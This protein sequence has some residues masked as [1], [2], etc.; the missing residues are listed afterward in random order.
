MMWTSSYWKRQGS[1]AC[2]LDSDSVYQGLT[3]RESEVRCRSRLFTAPRISVPLG[4]AR[5][6]DARCGWKQLSVES[7]FPSAKERWVALFPTGTFSQDRASKGTFRLCC[8]EHLVPVEATWCCRVCSSGWWTHKGFPLKSFHDR[9]EVFCLLCFFWFVFGHTCPP[10]GKCRVLT[11]GPPGNSQKTEVFKLELLLFASQGKE[12]VWVTQSYLLSLVQLFV[13]PWMVAGHPPP[14][15][16]FHRR[17]HWSGLPFPSPGDLPDPGSNSGL[18]HCRQIPYHLNHQVIW[19]DLFIF[20]L[21]P[22]L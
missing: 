3:Q 5:K 9:A 13:T 11:S 2:L 4:T 1:Y 18:W 15:M 16:E 17:E 19:S 14:S 7:P 6:A 12:K 20:S 21:L 8:L 22:Y 10:E